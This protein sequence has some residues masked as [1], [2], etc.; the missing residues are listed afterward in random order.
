M[1]KTVISITGDYYHKGKDINQYLQCVL[2]LLDEPVIYEN[3][4]L[5]ALSEGLSKN[6]A[7]IILS[8]ENQR[9]PQETNLNDWLTPE[10]SGLITAYVKHGGSWLGL[11]SGMSNYPIDSGYSQML[12]GYFIQHPEPLPVTYRCDLAEMPRQ[13]VIQDEHYQVGFVDDYTHVFLRSFSDA[14][15]SVAGW[16]HF[17]GNGKVAGYVPAHDI[18]GMLNQEN[19]ALL[20]IV[21]AW[22]LNPQ[23]SVRWK[24]YL[25]D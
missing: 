5:D 20:K 8:V 14:G 6:P 9:T 22:L 16:R 15:E 17:Y 21:V 18:S 10:M 2:S 7:L 12:K 1:V 23:S 24:D 25:K 19:L 3:I 11:H 13:F 4:P